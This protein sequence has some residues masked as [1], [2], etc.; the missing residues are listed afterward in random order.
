MPRCSTVNCS[1]GFYV[2][3]LSLRPSIGKRKIG[4]LDV[5]NDLRIGK[6][7]EKSLAYIRNVLCKPL[8]V[9]ATDIIT[10]ICFTR[11][12]E[13]YQN[14]CKL[15][16]FDG[17]A[18]HYEC[19]DTGVVRQ[20]QSILPRKL[21]T[22]VNA[23]MICLANINSHLH[24]GTRCKFLSKPD[25]DTADVEVNGAR[26]RIERRLWTST[27]KNGAVTGHRR[28]VP[29]KLNWASTVHKAQ[30]SQ[31]TKVRI[32]SQHE[33]TGGMLYVALS[34]VRRPNDV[35]V[36]GFSKD[37]LKSRENEL[38]ELNG[39][40]F[41]EF[42]EDLSCC[43]NK[44]I[45]PEADC[46]M[47]TATQANVDEEGDAYMNE[48]DEF[49]RENIPLT[50]EDEVL[51]LEIV[52]ESLENAEEY[53]A[54]PPQDFNYEVFLKEMQDTSIMCDSLFAQNKNTVIDRAITLLPKAE[55]F[56]KILWRKIFLWL[57][58][59]I[60]E[61]LGDTSMTMA[62]LK[63]VTKK[64][65]F[66]TCCEEVRALLMVVLSTD[67]KKSFLEEADICFCSDL[68]TKIYHQILEIVAN[69]VRQNITRA[70]IE[71][72]KVIELDNTGLSKIRFLGGYVAH[73]LL[74]ECKRYVNDNVYSEQHHVAKRVSMSVDKV[75]LLTENIIVP[76]EKIC[77]STKYPDTLDYI[78][79]RQYASRG[80]L[81]V[82]DSF[83]EYM[84][85]LEQARVNHLKISKYKE[86]GE[87]FLFEIKKQIVADDSFKLKQGFFE[88]FQNHS[89]AH[90]A[91]LEEVSIHVFLI[92]RELC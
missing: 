88:L 3:L 7:S 63:D 19:E 57:K 50:E 31:L 40:S 27:D 51:H 77:E 56:I 45:S 37:H 22:K 34:R 59:H 39:L 33:F 25:N 48:G 32:H 10:D 43:R 5:L 68:A 52:L 16:M 53:L 21:Y 13:E 2:I 58:K 76:Y 62:F 87:N 86:L 74:D 47:E 46:E 29:L 36:L 61:Q 81:H 75:R 20:N 12:E 11:M 65:W 49:V 30:G 66:I 92:P 73:R 55:L 91:E 28:Q 64:V 1:H 82:S 44:V 85:K 4:F 72:L 15:R 24:N 69:S 90:D 17:I 67:E 26:F 38:E 35:Q 6:C 54:E 41:K 84:L 18:M 78:E 89:P 80:L 79:R 70:A 23:P 8:Q 60:K 14:A 9:S 42:E 83:Y 71:D